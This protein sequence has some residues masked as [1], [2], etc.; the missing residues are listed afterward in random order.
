MT[1]RKT[2]FAEEPKNGND[3]VGEVRYARGPDTCVGA[4]QRN[5]NGHQLT[6]LSGEGG[7]DDRLPM[8]N[9]MSRLQGGKDKTTYTASH[10]RAPYRRRQAQRSCYTSTHGRLLSPL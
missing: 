10:T 3:P 4:Y 8:E 9:R 1:S 6:D 5:S 2:I 7:D